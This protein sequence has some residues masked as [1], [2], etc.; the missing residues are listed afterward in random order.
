MGNM[1]QVI[2]EI[3]PDH[4]II[5]TLDGL[6]NEEEKKEFANLVF[7]VASMSS[8]YDIEDPSKFTKR[9]MNMMLE[10]SGVEKSGGKVADA[11]VV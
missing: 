5:K 7:D 1:N 6:D 4:N 3:N 11:E 10:K 8:G 9:V 2:M